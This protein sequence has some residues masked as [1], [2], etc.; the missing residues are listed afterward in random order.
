M[1]GPSKLEGLC[2]ATIMK[3]SLLD[4]FISYKEH[5]S[6]VNMVPGIVFAIGNTPFSV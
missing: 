1:N 2:L 6:V 4:P 5:R 3:H